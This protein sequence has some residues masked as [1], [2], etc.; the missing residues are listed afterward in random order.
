M[1]ILAN[2]V[3]ARRPGAQPLFKN[4]SQTNTEPLE[5]SVDVA[6]VRTHE[7]L[8]EINQVL[9]QALIGLQFAHDNNA[10]TIVATVFDVASGELLRELS[11]EE[12][13][14]ISAVFDI[15]PGL[16]RQQSIL[17]KWC[18]SHK[19]GIPVGSA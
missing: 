3:A 11:A 12:V 8:A 17:K 9:R 6:P 1:M 14:Q 19:G 16:M 15:L 18:D 5:Q 13:V 10:G 7:L 4:W 2:K